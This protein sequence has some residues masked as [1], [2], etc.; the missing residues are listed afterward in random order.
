MTVKELREKLEQ[1]PDAF[2]VMGYD[3]DRNLEYD[4]DEVRYEDGEVHVIID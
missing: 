4:F 2:K 1:Y 3:W